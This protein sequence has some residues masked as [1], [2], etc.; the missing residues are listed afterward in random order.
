M[1]YYVYAVRPF[2]Q[3]TALGE[4]AA[5]AGASAQAKTLRAQQAV[6]DKAQIR[7]MFAATPIEAEDLLLQVRTPRPAG[8]E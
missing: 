2:A 6:D 3:L 7:V 8:E 5:Y 4:H 1:P